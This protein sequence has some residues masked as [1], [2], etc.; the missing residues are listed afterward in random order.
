MTN[1][2][3]LFAQA[4][5]GIVSRSTTERKKMSTKTI[6]K[7]VALVAV[8]G[9][10]SGLVSVA[11]ANAA[12][13][14]LE[15]EP[16]ILTAIATSSTT[17]VAVGSTT[18]VTVPVFVGAPAAL[19]A[20]KG[21]SV[22]TASVTK[23][24]GSTTPTISASI[25]NASATVF[26]ASGTTT[27]SKSQIELDGA[28]IETLANGTNG[29]TLGTAASGGSKVGDVTL[30]GFDKP[31]IYTFSIT[32]NGAAT[33]VAA[34]VT[35]YAGYSAD[36]SNPNRLFPTQG[37]NITTGWAAVANGQATV[38]LTGFPS[39][40][41]TYYATVSGNASLIAVTE[42]DTGSDLTN[43][44][45]NGTNLAGGATIVADS[46]TSAS[47]YEDLQLSVGATGTATVTV[48]T[49]DAA[50]GVSTTFAS[51][52]LTIGSTPAASATSS[53]VGISDGN[54]NPAP[55][56]DDSSSIVKSMASGNGT[57]LAN[58]GVTLKDQNGAN[59]NGQKITVTLDGP[60]LI[61]VEQNGDGVGA[62]AANRTYSDNTAN[63]GNVWQIG[64]A[65]DGT[66]GRLNVTIS[67]G[68]TVLAVKSVTFYGTA[69]KYTATAQLVAPTNGSSTNDAVVV[70]AT[71]KNG[72]TVPSHTIY[73]FSGDT[74]V[75]SVTPSATT[76]TTSRVAALIDGTNAAGS[77]IDYG[78][79]TYK[80]AKGS[81]CIGFAVNAVNQTL[82]D[83]VTI[84]FR[85][86]I[87]AAD[88]TVSTTA[89]VK[90]GAL[91]AL[92]A[93]VAFDK[94]SYAAGSKATVTLTFKDSV[95][96]LVGAQTG[97]DFLTG[98]LTSSAAL[99]G[100]ALFSA[101]RPNIFNGAVTADVF[102][103]YYA[104]TVTITG[105]TG[106]ASNLETA[107]KG[108]SLA[109]SA[110]VTAPADSTSAQLAS[111]IKK[112]NDLQKLI[113]KIQKRLGVK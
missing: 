111:L 105:T 25:A 48:V 94:A 26:V 86:A 41:G 33:D 91:K 53:L 9:L 85:D 69:A 7:R 1:E 78:Q 3:G 24:A 84:T 38:R 22:T 113:A 61:Q 51:A 37:S 68:A 34:T 40:G 50:S 62:V 28:V 57:I 88:A 64:I 104:G 72:N 60:G 87:A 63:T 90:V 52:V 102:M 112:I 42:G 18:A 89:T 44:L 110:A 70:C 103:P 47:A 17:P 31:G 101:T 80:A 4:D 6:Y 14:L 32:P 55:T 93:T 74:S 67:V 65:A 39:T 100:A 54:D 15:D 23:P 92:T 46:T 97:T 2:K 56:T 13:S 77:G 79:T 96:R 83:S 76:D 19:T 11:P 59:L 27:A 82:K 29:G 71:D 20:T 12:F 43:A 5:L 98:A 8:A 108:V 66:A 21:F 16:A 81:G 99:Q 10:V 106:Q 95:G 30:T 107:A 35:V 58:I 73:A 75:A 36:A 49:Y 109:A 45:T